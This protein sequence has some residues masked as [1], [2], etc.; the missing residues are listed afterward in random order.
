MKPKDLVR[1][2]ISATKI[3]QFIVDEWEVDLQHIIFGLDAQ[4]NYKGITRSFFTFTDVAVIFESLRE[5]ETDMISEQTSNNYNYYVVVK[6]IKHNKKSYRLVFC[7]H[8][9]CPN[10]ADVIT[11]FRSQ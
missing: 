4:K 11:F 1:G 8:N 7:I 9:D 5:I 10:L 2:K 3:N 6:K